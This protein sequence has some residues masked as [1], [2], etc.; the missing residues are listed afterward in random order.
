MDKWIYTE[1]EEKKK[2]WQG[3]T[4][5]LRAISRLVSFFHENVQ[6]TTKK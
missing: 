2:L 6:A 4:T 5:A 3:I 1:Q